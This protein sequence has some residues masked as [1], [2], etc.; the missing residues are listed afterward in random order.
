MPPAEN[1]TLFLSWGGGGGGGVQREGVVQA[2]WF[3]L[4]LRLWA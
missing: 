1:H 3:V 4:G 2:V